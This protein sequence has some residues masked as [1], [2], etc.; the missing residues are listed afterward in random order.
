MHSYSVCCIYTVYL[1]FFRWS[2]SLDG[3]KVDL[4]TI[5]DYEGIKDE[6]EPVF[7][8]KLFPDGEKSRPKK[9][10]NKKVFFVSSRV[11]PGETPSSFVFNGFVDLILRKDDERAKQLRKRYV[12]KL[13]PFLNPDGVKSGNYR[14]DSRGANLN[15]YYLQ[16]EFSLQPTIYAAKAV[17][18]YHHEANLS[19]R[20]HSITEKNETSQTLQDLCSSSSSQ[21][22]DQENFSIDQSKTILHKTNSVA[23]IEREPSLTFNDIHSN[24]NIEKNSSPT[25]GSFNSQNKNDTQ[26]GPL[27]IS[28]RKISTEIEKKSSGV[29]FY[30]DLH[31]HASKRGCFLYGNN[32]PDEE[33]QVGLSF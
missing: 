29:A 5:S 33:E 30:I 21:K 12:F 20:L 22:S 19:D 27:F 8:N 16:P 31:G 25:L 13:I 23:S 11:H 15:R 18:G 10:E 14:T 6:V 7:D 2:R 3:L 24:L 26:A 17:V 32:L 4:L 28:T 9:F 1:C